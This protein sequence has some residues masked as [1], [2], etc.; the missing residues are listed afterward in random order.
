M[1]LKMGVSSLLWTERFGAGDVGLFTKVKKAGFEVFEIC[2]ADPFDFPVDEVR[3]AADD[4]GIGLTT[5]SVAG[6]DRNPISPD[7]ACR[8]KAVDFLKQMIDINMGIG[9]PVVGGP[10]YAAWGYITGKARTN[11]EWKWAAETIRKAA[12]HAKQNGKV[13][14]ALEPINRFE[15]FFINIA[16][17]ALAMAKATGM[18]NVGVHLDTFHMIREETNIAEAVAACGERL[19]YCHVCE[20]TRGIPG[21]GLIPWA[22]FFGAVKKAGYTGPLTIESFDPNF[23]EINRTCAIWRKFAENGEQLATEGMK[24]LKAIAA[25]L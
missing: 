20:N 2:V 16:E 3:K 1:Q 5:I 13:R 7:A 11:D 19:F 12:E 22:E 6:N 23:E 15:T 21:T 4:A 25:P 8:A 10:N 24:N 14:I 9:S 18:D 17:D